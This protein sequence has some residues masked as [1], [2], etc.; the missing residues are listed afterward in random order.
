MWTHFEE[1]IYRPSGTSASSTSAKHLTSR[2]PLIS[3]RYGCSN[4][5]RKEC[6]ITSACVVG[7]GGILGSFPWGSRS[8]P[9]YSYIWRQKST[10]A[11]DR[12]LVPNNRHCMSL[13]PQIHK[14]AGQLLICS[15]ICPRRDGHPDPFRQRAALVVMQLSFKGNAL[16]FLRSP[17]SC[18]WAYTTWK[19]LSS[20]GYFG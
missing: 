11:N 13:S 7:D 17:L 15:V 9:P 1:T 16:A 19:S 10:L 20:H 18:A 5:F 6:Y 12:V 2:P 3:T 14:H 8:T 4:A